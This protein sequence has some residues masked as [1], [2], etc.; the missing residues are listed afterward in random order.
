LPLVCPH[1]GEPLRSLQ[2]DV[3]FACRACGRF[4]EAVGARFVERPGATA[5]PRGP[6]RPSLHLPVWAFRVESRW[7]WAEEARPRPAAD[8]P[9]ISCVYVTGFSLHNP[10]YFGDPGLIFTE[11]QVELQ[12]GDP[13]PFVGCVRGQ[14]MA[15]EYVASHLLTIL[16]RRMD[17]TGLELTCRIV[18]A[19]VW[20][21][22]FVE[23]DGGVEDCILGLRLP[24]AAL[25]DFAAMRALCQ[26]W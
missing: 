15:G 24:A 7:A 19:R 2:Q 23:K 22:P 13:A 1:C 5:R 6:G 11:R 20:A 18:E 26:R 21:V 10:A 9:A 8:L 3:V 25:N 16:D 17:V 4:L 12:A 14:E